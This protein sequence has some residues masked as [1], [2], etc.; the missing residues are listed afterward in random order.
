MFP[1]VK[2]TYQFS[3]CKLISIII[4]Q[5]GIEY[6]NTQYLEQNTFNLLFL[7]QCIQMSSRYNVIAR[8]QTYINF[9]QIITSLS[10]FK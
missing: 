3:T 5:M 1:K 9:L 4:N 2:S 8:H 10:F 6:T 7:V